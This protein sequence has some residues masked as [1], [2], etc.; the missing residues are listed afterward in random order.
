MPSGSSPDRAGSKSAGPAAAEAGIKSLADA[1]HADDVERTLTTLADNEV[2]ALQNLANVYTNKDKGALPGPLLDIPGEDAKAPRV[3]N[4][5][6]APRVVQD[7]ASLPPIAEE[8]T[9]DTAVWREVT[10]I[11]GKHRRRAQRRKKKQEL[12]ATKPVGHSCS[13][14]TLADSIFCC[15]SS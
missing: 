3:K 4:P 5:I 12:E 6:E 1:L 14:T 11:N 7:T 9:D 2:A 15:T 10:D 8:A 13:D